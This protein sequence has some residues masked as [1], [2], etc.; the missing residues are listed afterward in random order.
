M[1]DFRGRAP[2]NLIQINP[3]WK[4]LRFCAGWTCRSGGKG[5]VPMGYK[6]ILLLVSGEDAAATG[7]RDGALAL[8]AACEAHLVA[9]CLVGEPQVYPTMG[10]SMPI[11][12]LQAERERSEA[13]ADELLAGVRAAADRAGVRTDLRRETVMADDLAN[14]FAR[15]GRHADLILVGQPDPDDTRS[16]GSILVETAFMSTGTPAMIIPYIGAGPMPPRQ[17][18]CCWDGSR[19]SA[20]AIRDALPLLAMARSA[21]LMVVEPERLGDRVGQ[22]PG[23]DIATFLARHGV[24]VAIRTEPAADLGVGD[25]LLSAASDQGADLIVMGGYGHSRLR[26]VVFGGTTSHLLAHMTVPLLLSH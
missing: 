1:A 14:V 19:E 5:A 8:A 26:E 15:H 20:R 4:T 12:L 21:T 2:A 6:T 18:M 13:R 22:Q 11:D 25:V 3:L 9:L 24:R 16:S 7:C 10:V 23:A 17:V